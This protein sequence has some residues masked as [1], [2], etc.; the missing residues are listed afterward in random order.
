MAT[1]TQMLVGYPKY[2]LDE[3]NISD[4]FDSLSDKEC[5]ESNS[6]KQKQLKNE[7][8]AISFCPSQFLLFVG[9]CHVL[10]VDL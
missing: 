8:E 10:S 3:F 2:V 4:D 6:N 9:C 5:H 1:K 7:G